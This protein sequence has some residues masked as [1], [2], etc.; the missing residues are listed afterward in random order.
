MLD[1]HPP[2]HGIHGVRDFFLHLFT[3]T[4]GLLIAIGLEQSVEAMHHRHQRKEAEMLIR[5]EIRENRKAIQDGAAGLK[6]EISGMREVLQSLEAISDGHAGALSENELQFR[7]GPMQDSAWRTA[8]TTGTLSYM[9]YGEVEKFSQAYKEQDLLQT[10]EQSTL[11]DYLQLAPILH[12]TGGA[13]DA[14]R[15]KEALPYAR[16]AM[17]HLSGMYFIG[18]GTLGAY[19]DAL[20]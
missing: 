11:S 3:I 8:S 5:E 6:T 7:E 20:K 16:N 1:V 15:A 19:E 10:M 13:V 2:E 17:G 9:D 12:G 4:V 14:A 18:A